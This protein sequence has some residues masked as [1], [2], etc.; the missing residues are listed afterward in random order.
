M[1]GKEGS[2]NLKD[3]MPKEFPKGL[4]RKDRLLI[5][6]LTGVLLVVIAIPSSGTSNSRKNTVEEKST[7]AGEAFAGE[8]SAYTE[9]LESHLA[10][11]LGT[12]EGVGKVKVMVTL[13]ASTEKIVGKDVE[14]S[15]ESIQEEDSQGGTR[16]SGNNSTKETTVYESGDSGASGQSP[17]VTKEISPVIEG[18]IV[19]ATGGANPVT[20]AN[21][22]DAVQAL[23]DID[24]H[25]IKVMKLN[26]NK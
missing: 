26:Q 13:K 5:L 7:A 9:Y 22:T 19:I 2:K 12:V 8:M 10:A 20:A 1:D 4:L 16:A 3:Y 25:K 6:L 11:V 23:F 21:I 18:V 14:H 24:T 15:N 17:Y